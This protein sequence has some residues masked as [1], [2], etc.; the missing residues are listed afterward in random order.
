MDTYDVWDELFN[1]EELSKKLKENKGDTKFEDLPDGSYE[2]K[3]KS[4]ELVANK[5]NNPM[6]TVKFE[7][8]AGD[9][10]G[11][12]IFMNQVVTQGFQLHKMDTFLESLDSGIE[13]GFENYTQYKNLLL[14]VAEAI[15]S[16]GLDYNL[17]YGTDKKGYRTFE[18][19]EIFEPEK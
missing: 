6:V 17:K 10:K 19:E 3:V 9:Y 2:V 12:L 8:L 18:I 5:N 16:A 7:V 15:N 13:I 14:D 1:S 4:I 11:K